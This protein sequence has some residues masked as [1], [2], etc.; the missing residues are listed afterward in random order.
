MHKTL[1]ISSDR[2]I[3]S[4]PIEWSSFRLQPGEVVMHFPRLLCAAI[5]KN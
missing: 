5:D 3:V 2:V 4:L 1:V